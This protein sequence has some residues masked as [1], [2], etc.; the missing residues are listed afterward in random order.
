[1]T[2]ADMDFKAPPEVIEALAKRVEHGIF[3]Y[4]RMVDEDYDIILHWIKARHGQVVPREWLLPGPGVVYTMRAAQYVMTKPG[5]KIV[6]CPPVHPPFF[7]TASCFGRQMVSV[8][9]LCD[10][11]N[12]YTMD[13]AGIEKAFADGG[14]RILGMRPDIRPL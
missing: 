6:V 7:T 4:T 14:W 10:E 9:L 1:M 2:L 5:D 12:Y 8:P 11:N 3:G 13:F